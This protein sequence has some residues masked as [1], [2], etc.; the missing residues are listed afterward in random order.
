M[1]GKIAVSS[2]VFAIDK[3]YSY[4]IPEGMDLRPGHRVQVPFGRGNRI[5]EGIVLSVEA[6][7][8]AGL[9][10]IQ[11]VMEEEPMLT[12]MQLRMAAFLRERYFCTFFD[13]IRAMLPAGAWFQ[14][15]ATFRLTEDRTWK[16]KTIRKAGAVPILELLETLGGEAEENAL[17]AAVSDEEIFGA[18]IAYLMQK[19]WIATEQEFR[20]RLSDKTEKVA[21]LAVPA[22]QAMEFASSRPKSAALQRA[23]LELLS[24]V[25]SSAVKDLGYYTG[26]SPAV[27]KRL[28]KLGFVTLSERPVL[29]CREIQPAKID[30]PLVLNAEQEAVFQGLSQQMRREKPGTALLHGVTGSG[31][32][33]VYIRLIQECLSDGKA[34]LLMVPEIALTP[35]LLGL[36]AAW[37]GDTVAILHSSLSMGERY[38]QW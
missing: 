7:D 16:E 38:D 25:G 15:R 37:F 5:A 27:L 4:R 20:P 26:A 19:K 11:R 29:R 24:S 35:Q 33:S 10:A 28:E 12:P 17:R 8:E 34:A 13:A 1:I 3:P 6:G 18:A 2:A 30:G 36:M 9:K 31:K 14:T 21:A 22:E 32:T 23:V